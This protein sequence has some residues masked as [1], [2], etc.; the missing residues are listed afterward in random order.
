MLPEH[1]L[2]KAASR[3][4]RFGP[5]AAASAARRPADVGGEDSFR[6]AAAGERLFRKRRSEVWVNCG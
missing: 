2:T 6:A 5:L 1:A 3:I 4:P